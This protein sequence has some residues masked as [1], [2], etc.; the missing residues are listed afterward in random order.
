[1]RNKHCPWCREIVL[2]VDGYSDVKT[3]KQQ[4]RDLLIAQQQRAMPSFYCCTHGT[5]RPKNSVCFSPAAAAAPSHAVRSNSERSNGV[6][7]NLITERS[8]YLCGR[9]EIQKSSAAYSMF[10]TQ[11]TE[12]ESTD[13]VLPVVVPET[14][15]VAVGARI[16]GDAPSETTSSQHEDASRRSER[17]CLDDHVAGIAGDEQV[18]ERT[19]DLP[20]DKEDQHIADGEDAD[21]TGGESSSSSNGSSSLTLVP[22]TDSLL[23]PVEQQ[24]LKH[25]R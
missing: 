11:T 13:P 25:S 12:N 22:S 4:I 19:N 21:D 20:I 15:A 5:V 3:T 7:V 16:S 24:F 2:P 23:L 10:G 9:D 6:T 17:R 14:S 1:L 18:F 8:T